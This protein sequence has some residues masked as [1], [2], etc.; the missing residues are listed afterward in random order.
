MAEEPKVD[1]EGEVQQVMLEPKDGGPFHATERM[2]RVEVTVKGKQVQSTQPIQYPGASLR[3]VYAGWAMKGLISSGDELY[4]VSD[5]AD[6]LNS[7]RGHDKPN[8][9]TWVEA[10]SILSGEIA[11]AMLK[12][13]RRHDVATGPGSE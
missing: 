12:E 13:K 11:D 10:L 2:E 8:R 6:L 7:D 1:E 3:D 5:L 4:K 9:E